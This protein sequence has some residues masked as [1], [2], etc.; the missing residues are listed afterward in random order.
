MGWRGGFLLIINRGR[1]DNS[2]ASEQDQSRV[3]VG[4]RDWGSERDSENQG[5]RLRVQ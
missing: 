4:G 3:S 5:P 1:T 2:E